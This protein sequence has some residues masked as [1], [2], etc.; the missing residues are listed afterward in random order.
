[1]V[2]T[3][4][5]TCLILCFVETYITGEYIKK[6]IHE[7]TSETNNV[8]VEFISDE[9]VRAK[10]FKLD[11]KSIPCCKYGLHRLMYFKKW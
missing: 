2:I 1:M 10:G 4:T 3:G 8:V 5:V 6:N 7:F 9:Y 11:L